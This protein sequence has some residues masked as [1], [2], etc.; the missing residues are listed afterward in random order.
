MIFGINDAAH[1]LAPR[2]YLRRRQS[3]HGGIGEA[4]VKSGAY[5]C[6]FS[7]FPTSIEDLMTIADAGGIM[8]PKSTWFEPKLR[9]A[10]FCHASWYAGG[11][12]LF[13]F[14][15]AES[16]SAWRCNSQSS[17][18]PFAQLNAHR[19]SA[20]G[21]FLEDDRQSRTAGD[22]QRNEPAEI[23]LVADE[24]DGLPGDGRIVFNWCTS[25]SMFPDGAR[26]SLVR[27]SYRSSSR[28][29]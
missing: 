20:Q 1:E 14:G 29:P 2:D 13:A 15:R 25:S 10:M 19:Q 22:E 17:V 9:D 6:A 4:S 23:G 26:C 28:A 11:R 27:K 12:R 5:A 18:A 16:Q 24:H 21:A 8:P 3:R 7:M